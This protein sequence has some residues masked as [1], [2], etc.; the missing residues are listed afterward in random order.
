MPSVAILAQDILWEPILDP[1]ESITSRSMRSDVAVLGGISAGAIAVLN[2]LSSAVHELRSVCD[3]CIQQEGKYAQPFSLI[4]VLLLTVVLAAL[5]VKIFGPASVRT[6]VCSCCS[7]PLVRQDVT[8]V[9]VFGPTDANGSSATP[10]DSLPKKKFRG[11][12]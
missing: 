9:D 1:L 11:Q 8:A 10:P 4:A 2:Y 3:H 7:G 5:I 6:S 12:Q